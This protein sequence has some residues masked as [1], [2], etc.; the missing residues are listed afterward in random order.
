MSDKPQWLTDLRDA[1]LRAKA[2]EHAATLAPG[3]ADKASAARRASA[4][5]YDRLEP[6]AVLWLLEVLE[7]AVLSSRNA[8]LAQ[9]FR[10]GPRESR[11]PDM[12]VVDS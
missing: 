3:D 9:D 8:L 7:G 11:D 1:A 2:A 10:S 6:N 12:T 4:A 5:M